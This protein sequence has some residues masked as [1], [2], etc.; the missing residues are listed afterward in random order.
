MLYRKVE[1]ITLIILALSDPGM[2][3]Q[4]IPDILNIL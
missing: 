3:V 2:C 1:I 4:H